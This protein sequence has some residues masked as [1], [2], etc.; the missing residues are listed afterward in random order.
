MWH[1]EAKLREMCHCPNTFV[2]SCQSRCIV[3]LHCCNTTKTMQDLVLLT[4]W[5]DFPAD[6][7]QLVLQLCGHDGGLASIN[8]IGHTVDLVPYP[9]QPEVTL[10]LW[11]QR[12]RGVELSHS[13]VE[14]EVYDTEKKARK[15]I[16]A[17]SFI[18]YPGESDK[19]F[20]LIQ[21]WQMTFK[22]ADD[23]IHVK[24]HPCAFFQSHGVT[25]NDGQRTSSSSRFHFVGA[26]L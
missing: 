3:H 2:P 8:N 7:F 11:I 17:K 18:L 21:V 4:Q 10:A 12:Y 15:W 24:P 9:W 22:D 16:S 1:T 26:K 23:I 6:S 13:W 14:R 19:K 20:Y 5:V 25:Q